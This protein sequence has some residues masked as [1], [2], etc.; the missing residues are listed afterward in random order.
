LPDRE[1]KSP[2]QLAVAL[3]NADILQVLDQYTS[4]DRE[5]TR[6]ALSLQMKQRKP[7]DEARM[8]AV[9][10][11]FFENATKMMLAREIQEERVNAANAPRRKHQS[12]SYGN[13][14]DIDVLDELDGD[15]QWAWTASTAKAVV[16]D[17]PASRRAAAAGKAASVEAAIMYW[18]D[19]V[20]MHQNRDGSDQY[21]FLRK[22]SG[23]GSE[24]VWLEDHIYASYHL[25]AQLTVQPTPTKEITE[26]RLPR[27][28]L[29][30]LKFGWVTYYDALSNR[31]LWLNVH[32][33]RCENTL[34]LGGDPMLGPA[35][36][37]DALQDAVNEEVEA[38][39]TVANS[40]V[41]VVKEPKDDPFSPSLNA[42]AKSDGSD[43]T[44]EWDAWDE[45]V[46]EVGGM[47]EWDQ[48][49]YYNRITAATSFTPPHN[50]D[51][52]N[53]KRGGWQLVCSEASERAYYWYHRA[54]GESAW[55]EV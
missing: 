17:T 23:N 22:S 12:A 40:W 37:W 21:Y 28:V 14:Y 1:G 7:V 34:P 26:A 50:Y 42:Q 51:E 35:G 49:Y 25:H 11:A 24:A 10:E 52:I 6:V 13:S 45:A 31:C 41:L 18:Y 43:Q 39:A 53:E 55:V 46:Q 48:P 20:L 2:R 30:S 3:G 54:S 5:E 9:W 8:M 47:G 36:L 29:D 33:W 19:H 4:A 16:Q 27:L 44:F 38:D 15:D 32:T